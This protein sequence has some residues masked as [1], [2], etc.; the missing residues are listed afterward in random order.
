VLARPPLRRPPRESGCGA[1]DGASAS[2]LRAG[3]PVLLP[4]QVRAARVRCCR[5]GERRRARLRPQVDSRKGL[6]RA[7]LRRS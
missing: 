4:A 3:H 1:R 5:T 2:P 6:A 7:V